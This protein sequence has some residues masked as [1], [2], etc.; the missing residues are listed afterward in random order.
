MSS[1]IKDAKKN[2]KSANVEMTEAKE[3]G[4]DNNKNTLFICV[5]ISIVVILLLILMSADKKEP[6]IE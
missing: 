4:K 6:V 2:I 1:N 5:C 3:Y